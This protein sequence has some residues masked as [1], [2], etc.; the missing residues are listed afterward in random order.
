MALYHQVMSYY[1]KQCWLIISEV[2]WQSPQCNFTRNA[3]CIEL[4][5]NDMFVRN[6]N[7]RLE[8]HLHGANESLQW[9]NPRMLTQRIGLILGLCPANERH[10]VYPKNFHDSSDI[11][12]MGS[13]YSIQIREISH[14]KF[15]PSHRKCPTSPMIFV[16]T[17]HHNKVTPSL[18]GWAQT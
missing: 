2:L 9:V 18:I 11:C 14:R 5:L 16:N 1:L 8:L 17:G 3:Q 7:L 10:P 4:S 13:M 12:P 15:G 6:T